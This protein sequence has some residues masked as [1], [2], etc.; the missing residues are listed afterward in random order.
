MWVLLPH[1]VS[2]FHAWSLVYNSLP[3][4]CPEPRAK[5]WYHDV[6]QKQ[7]HR[8]DRYY[9]WLWKAQDLLLH[10][11][12]FSNQWEDKS[13]KRKQ[14]CFESHRKTSTWLH[15]APALMIRGLLGRAGPQ[16]ITSHFAD[17]SQDRNTCLSLFI[18][19]HRASGLIPEYTI[20][21]QG[22]TTKAAYLDLLY[23]CVL[24]TWGTQSTAS[25][26]DAFVSVVTLSTRSL[27]HTSSEPQSLVKGI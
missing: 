9:H 4:L 19:T 14:I 11:M 10:E 22:K 13:L 17:D 15:R 8:S 18:H 24:S 25:H 3:R 21:S 5:N 26:L 27:T 7:H 2:W 16:M 23:H 1:Y 20:T 12:H 6:R